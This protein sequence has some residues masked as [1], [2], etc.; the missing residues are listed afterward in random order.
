MQLQ[1]ITHITGTIKLLTGLHIG[2]GDAALEIGGLDQPIIKHPLTGEPYIPGSSLKGKMRSLLEVKY[3]KLKGDGGPCDC[4]KCIVC[5]LFGFSGA[6]KSKTKIGPTRI[7]VRDAYMTEKWKNEF[8]NGDLP[9]E[10][11]YENVINRI[12]GTAENPRPL[13][14]VP[15]GVEFDFNISVRLFDLDGQNKNN[16]LTAI[17][18]AMALLELDALGGC[19][20]RGCGQIKFCN[21]RIDEEEVKYEH[22]QEALKADVPVGLQSENGD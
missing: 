20:S 2:G 4:G 22:L 8:R 7:L 9:M 14:R 1:K 15:A 18:Q 12:K 13:E 21:V 17:K 5:C 16:I 11:K 6:E 10:I 19:G 3:N